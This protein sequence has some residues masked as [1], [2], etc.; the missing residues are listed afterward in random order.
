MFVTQINFGT[1]K[2]SK[3]YLQHYFLKNKF[4][5]EMEIDWHGYFCGLI[6]LNLTKL[7]NIYKKIPVIFPCIYGQT[8]TNRY[9]PH[10]KLCFNPLK[11]GHL[12]QVCTYSR[13]SKVCSLFMELGLYI[14]ETATAVQASFN[15]FLTFSI[16]FLERT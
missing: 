12:T 7:N 9:Q 3:L 8:S 15:F 16:I 5:K 11:S 13:Q 6:N 1:I 4:K 2:L 10:T 14:V